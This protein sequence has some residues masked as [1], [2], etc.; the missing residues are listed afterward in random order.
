MGREHMQ[1]WRTATI[2]LVMITPSFGQTVPGKLVVLG[3]VLDPSGA[4]MPGATVQ[5]LK[6][7]NNPEQSLVTDETGSFRFTQVA[8]GR[9]QIYVRRESFKPTS[10]RVVVRDRDPA[11][12]RITLPIAELR[13]VVVASDQ[14]GQVSTDPRENLDVVKLDRKALNDLPMLDQDVIGGV[15]RFLDSSALGSGGTTL[16]VNGL[17]VSRIGVSASGIREVKINQNPY[18]AEFARPGRGRIEIVT[19]AGAEDYHGTFNFLFR[20]YHLNARNAFAQER[21]P[22]QRKIF[23]GEF[24]G[25]IGHSGKTSFLITA[26]HEEQDLQAVVYASTPNGLIRANVAT[27]EGQTEFSVGVNHQFG[28]RHTVSIRYEFGHDYTR[29]SGVGEFNLPEVGADQF[30]REHHLFYSHRTVFSTK[31]VNEL[32]LHAASEDDRTH[33]LHPGV[34][35]INVVDAFTGGGAQADR[36]ATRNHLQLSD[37]VI[38]LRGKHTIKAGINITDLGRRGASDRSNFDGT[39][40]FSTLDDYLRGTPFSF[41]SNRGDPH[42]A[43]WQTVFGAFVQDD[44][45][46]RPN[47]SLGLGLRYDLQKHI[48][49]HNNVSPRM[50]FAYS[51]DRKRKTVFRGGA[52]FFYDRT[53]DGAIGDALRYDGQRLRQ[54]LITDPSYPNPWSSAA[55]LLLIPP[56]V[57]RFAPGIRSPYTVQYGV[58]VER[59]LRKSTTLAVNC[60]EIRGVKLFR[61]RDINAPLPPY[62]SQRP[63]QTMGRVRQIESSAS[64]RSRSLEILFR[65]NLSRFFNG[66]IQY[67]TGR[68]YNNASGIN[69]LP[70]NSYDLSGE[71]S[72]ADFDERHRFNMLGAFKAGELFTFG[73]SASLTSG[74]PYSLTLGRDMN[75]DGNA[76]DRPPGVRRNSLQGPGSATLDLRWSKD[77]PLTKKKKEDGPAVTIALNVFNVLNRV[78]YAGYVGNLSSPFFGQPVAARPARRMQLALK[79]EF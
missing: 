49:D 21:P 76:N 77:L 23:E 73:V 59:Q 22:E 31:L 27:P 42:L 54:V 12:I 61:S 71:W 78:N 48:P 68:A 37:A 38:W 46:L 3:T 10:V 67:M 52:G 66:T 45:R 19:K 36:R 18:S 63:D 20:D 69:S 56:S 72:R 25:P 24:N 26:N 35:Q 58:G 39:Y 53:S 51:P 5:L 29:N 34:R 75:H 40:T 9:Y 30:S 47:L 17:E 55:N 79:F 7:T 44:F 8:P 74:R 16:V 14:A 2:L 28:K 11:P 41:Q 4:S 65:G 33:S 6:G 62:Y 50:S 57:V 43:Y 60:V 64:S 32:S 15:S 70:A 13:E 1:F